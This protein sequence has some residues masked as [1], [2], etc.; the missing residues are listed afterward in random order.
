ML[1]PMMSGNW[2]AAFTGDIANNAMA[3]MLY[4]NVFMLFVIYLTN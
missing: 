1:S 3:I 4:E 2:I